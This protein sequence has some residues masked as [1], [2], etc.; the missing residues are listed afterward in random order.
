[1]GFK[2]DLLLCTSLECETGEEML[3]SMDLAKKEG[4]DIVELCFGSMSFS[5]IS[6]VEHIFKLRILPS[7]VSFG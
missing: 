2:S 7:I 1:M 4:A 6:D 5:H 3:V